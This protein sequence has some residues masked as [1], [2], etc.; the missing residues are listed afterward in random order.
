MN[1]S[2]MRYLTYWTVTGNAI[3][4]AKAVDNTDPQGKGLRSHFRD[5]VHCID[6]P[7]RIATGYENKCGILWPTY[8]MRE[9]A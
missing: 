3:Q 9:G 8:T 1:H 4:T 7:D 2:Y 6:A 5:S